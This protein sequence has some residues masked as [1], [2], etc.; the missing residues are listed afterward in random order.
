LV[1]FLIN[2]ASVSLHMRDDF[3]RTPMHDCCWRAEPDL[4]L[5][6]MLLDKAPE[7]LMLSDKRGH[8]PLDY[9]RR[10]HWD[11]LV[12]FLQERSAKLRSV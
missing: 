10:E 7:L 2:E 12:P 9:S 1:S 4:E 3:G 6:D 8:T 5:F 11:I